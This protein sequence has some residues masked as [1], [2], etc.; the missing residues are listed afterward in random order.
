[1]N[2]VSFKDLTRLS[3]SLFN[4]PL[5]LAGALLP[6]VQG[7]PL[8]SGEWVRW[9]WVVPA[10]FAARISGMSFNQ[11]ID[12]RIDTRNPRTKNRAIPTGRVSPNEARLIAWGSLLLFVVICWQINRICFALSFIAAFLLYIYSYMKRFHASCHFVLG[13]IF[14]LG[15]LMAAAAI[16]GRLSWPPVWLGLTALLSNCA[17]DI[18]YAIQDYEFD[19]ANALHSIPVRLGIKRTLVFARVLHLLALVSLVWLGISAKLPLF[20]Y[21]SACILGIV[22]FQF[23]IAVHKQF[24]KTGMVSGI[25]S[26][27]FLSQVAV[28]ITIFLFILLSLLWVV[29]F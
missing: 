16:S 4:L 5:I 23:H 2:F 29:L 3:Q 17:N 26:V 18:L 14:L 7:Y 13:S 12:Y 15:P 10:F 8:A 21:L 25:E 9:L 20:Y 27:F 11:L 28:A 19:K 1:M 6:F 22:F 24:K